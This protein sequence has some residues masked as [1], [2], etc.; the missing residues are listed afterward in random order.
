MSTEKRTS[1]RANAANLEKGGTARGRAEEGVTDAASDIKVHLLD[2]GSGDKHQ[3]GDCVLCHFGGTSVLIDGGHRGDEG[4]VS[5]SSK[6]C[7]IRPRP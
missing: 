7:S 2:I 5:V 1:G 6:N 3:Y 4:L